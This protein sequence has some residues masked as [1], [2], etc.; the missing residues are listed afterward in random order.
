MR[1]L[2]RLPQDLN[3]Q[4]VDGDTALHHACKIDRARMVYNLLIM[5]ADRN[6]RNREN[7]TPFEIAMLNQNS[8]VINLF[9]R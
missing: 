8:T 2:C 7:M 5:N 1:Y 9:A 6:I 4:D 3:V